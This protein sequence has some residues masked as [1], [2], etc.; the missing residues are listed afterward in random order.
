MASH[1]QR[2]NA[3][4]STGRR[5]KDI[6]PYR[7]L[8]SLIKAEDDPPENQEPEEEDPGVSFQNE[9]EIVEKKLTSPLYICKKTQLEILKTYF[10]PYPLI[11]FR[12]KVL[13]VK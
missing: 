8:K 13:L 9:A 2:R 4:I 1:D 3:C 11:E 5:R 7:L 10:D 12:K 6:A